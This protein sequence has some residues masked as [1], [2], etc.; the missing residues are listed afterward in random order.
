[1]NATRRFAASRGFTLL[2]IVLA[3]ALS[4]GVLYLLATAME[5]FMF[6][7][8]SS[9]SR[10]EAAQVARAVFDRLDQDLQ[11]LRVVPP[12]RSA[13]GSGGSGT[14]AGGDSGGA[15]PGAGAG[16]TDQ[17]GSPTGSSSPSSSQAAPF[18]GTATEL[19]FDRGAARGWERLTRQLETAEPTAAETFPATVRYWLL[20]ED[21]RT[22]AALAAAGAT[23]EP[24]KRIS[25]LYRDAIA[26]AAART[27]Q[28]SSG[29]GSIASS[30][31]VGGSTLELPAKADTQLLAPEI[32]ELKFAYF[33]GT[34]LL[35]QWDPTVTP[36]LPVG[37]EATLR[38]LETS[39]EA[40]VEA[41]QN[42]QLE[43]KLVEERHVVVYRRFIRMPSAAPAPPDQMLLRPSQGGGQ[44][45]GQ[46]RGG[47]P[48]GGQNGGD[49]QEGEGQVPAA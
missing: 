9:R 36:G 18:V 28:S 23:A 46:G 7:V 48:G 35:E 5:L 44:G 33:D 25:G 12:P 13:G 31:P 30:A 11:A 3:L 43:R 22:A 37:I 29:I 34:N 20:D 45:G 38:V 40:A 42:A 24:T 6:R 39:Y 8:D 17:Q 15:S 19:R 4:T 41:Q 16:A 1:M 47:G 14:G 26:T 21:R 27:A 32:L 49:Q 10:V 2:E